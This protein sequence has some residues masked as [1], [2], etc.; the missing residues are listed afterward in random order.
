MFG[1]TPHCEANLISSAAIGA[2][3]NIDSCLVDR[4]SFAAASLQFSDNDCVS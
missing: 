2:M 3:N 4:L 1:I